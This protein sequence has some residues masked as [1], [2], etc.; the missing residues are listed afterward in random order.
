MV[1]YYGEREGLVLFRKHLVRYLQPLTVPEETRAALLNTISLPAFEEHLSRQ[2]GLQ[3]SPQPFDARPP[4]A[5][6]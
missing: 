5:L 4:A 2:E 3:G 6:E 1:S